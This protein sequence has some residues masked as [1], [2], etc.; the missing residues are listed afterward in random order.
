MDGWM[1]ECNE[2]VGNRHARPT[3]S[4]RPTG[5]VQGICCGHLGCKLTLEIRLSKVVPFLPWEKAVD[6][7]Y[8]FQPIVPID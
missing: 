2:E 1:D 3:Q 8:N 4:N 7:K 6:I 5:G